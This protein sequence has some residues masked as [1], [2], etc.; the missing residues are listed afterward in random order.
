MQEFKIVDD[1]PDEKKREIGYQLAPNAARYEIK[2]YFVSADQIKWVTD[3]NITSVNR[4][5]R[6]SLNENK[7]TEAQDQLEIKAPPGY[8]ISKSIEKETAKWGESIIVSLKEPKDGKENQLFTYYLASNQAD[9]TRKAIDQTPKTI[10][11]YVDWKDPKLTSVTGEAGSDVAG[12]GQIT[13]N[14]DGKYYYIV[15]PREAGA[16]EEQNDSGERIVT[17]EF[18]KNRVA[19]HY[20]IVGYGRIEA[21][22]DQVKKPAEIAFNGLMAETDYVVYAYMEDEAGNESDVV[23]SGPFTTDKIA[24]AG[25]VEIIGTMAL[26]QTLTAQ[27]KLDSASP[28]DLTYQWYRIS[29]KDDQ[30]GLDE[31]WD[32]TGGAEAD[33]LEAE[34]DEEDEDEDEDDDYEMNSI[35]KFANA[36]SESDDVTVIDENEAKLIEGATQQTYKITREDI[37]HRLICQVSAANYSGYVAGESKTFVPKLIPE[38]TLP[39][40]GSAVYSPTRHL[41]SIKLP[42]RWSWVDD[43]I[44]PVYGNSGY[45][46][47][48]VPENTTLYRTVIV[49]VKVPVTKKSLTKK[50]LTLKKTYAYTGKAI[51]DN[52]YMEDGETELVSR[53]DYKATYRN[54]KKLGK[55]YITIKGIG[56]YK[57]QI[58][59]SYKI[60]TR[61][62]KS[63]KFSYSKKKVYT[64]KART[65]GLVIKNGSVKLKKDRDYTI[66]YKNNIG[67]G[68]ATIVIQGKGNYKGKKTL[69]FQIIPSKPKI[70]KVT[71]KKTSFRLKFSQNKQAKGIRVFVSTS[72]TFAKKKT[73]EYI[74]TGNHFGVYGLTAGT[75]YVRIRCYSSKKGKNYESSYSKSRK[76]K[77]KK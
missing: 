37:G 17:Q 10:T 74:T 39:V 9:N 71:K 60:I 54:N 76:I 42:E 72:K 20:G 44:V 45:R 6:E 7:E 8:L 75:Y 61:S 3:N 41:S 38:L 68:K 14:E 69:H 35:H 48:Y 58:K 77:I 19:S 59:A 12:T 64:G 53:K 4:K 34:D 57:G 2:P 5:A 49:R 25:L 40:I 27:V 33:D 50:M 66:T 28:G 65:A 11:I 13:G 56:N 52:F 47:R 55:A 30:A 63:L 21:S 1:R 36:E 31:E 29:R 67:I 24:L 32:E 18:I 22:T 51:K 43:T 26:D 23:T 15:L 16:G 73:Q 70:V 46:A 62:V